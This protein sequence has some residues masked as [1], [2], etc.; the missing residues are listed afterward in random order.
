MFLNTSGKIPEHSDKLTKCSNVLLIEGKISF[1]TSAFIV[2]D[3]DAV[4]F[5]MSLINR[6]SCSSVICRGLRTFKGGLGFFSEFLRDLFG[7]LA[8]YP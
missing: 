2:S 4:E 6:A 7:A 3:P 8:F 5:F 1:N